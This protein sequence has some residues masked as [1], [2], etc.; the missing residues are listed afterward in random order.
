VRHLCDVF[1]PVGTNLFRDGVSPSLQ[2]C[3]LGAIVDQYQRH[4]VDFSADLHA[5]ARIALDVGP[6]RL[7]IGK[8]LL[9]SE[10]SFAPLHVEFVATTDN[11]DR[12]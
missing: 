5:H 12:H 7:G 3:N 10:I 9:Q 11:V 2:L 8:L 6:P 4:F 1:F